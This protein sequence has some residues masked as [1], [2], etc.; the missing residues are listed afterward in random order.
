MIVQKDFRFDASH[1]LTNYHG[2]CESLHG[3]TYY[4]S[5]CIEGE[6]DANTGMVIDFLAISTVVHEVILSK[7]DHN[8]LNDF[9][10]NPSTEIIA[11]WIFDTLAPHFQT[12]SFYLSSIQLS[13]TP[14]NHVIYTKEDYARHSERN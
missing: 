8:H 1:F 10:E 4:L 12:N 6:V 11:K 13:E 3:H 5:V 2:K 7:F 9:F 14:T